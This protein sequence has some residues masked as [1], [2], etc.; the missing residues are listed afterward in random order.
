MPGDPRGAVKIVRSKILVAKKV[1]RLARFT[2]S[3]AQHD[4]LRTTF[5]S[6]SFEPSLSPLLAAQ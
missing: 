5:T 1:K 2:L 3:K 6:F 4:G